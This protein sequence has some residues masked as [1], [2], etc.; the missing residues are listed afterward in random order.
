MYVQKGYYSGVKGLRSDWGLTSLFLDVCQAPHGPLL[1]VV[2]LA[3]VAG[4]GPDSLVADPVEV[5]RAE[6]LLLRAV[7]P[8]VFA[9]AGVELLCKGL[10]ERGGGAQVRPVVPNG[11]QWAKHFRG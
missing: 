2:G 8:H 5:G 9:D 6:Q 11:F 7:A 10:K 1:R 3:G 4:G